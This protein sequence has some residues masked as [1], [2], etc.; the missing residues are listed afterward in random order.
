MYAD[1]VANCADTAIKLQNQI[2]TVSEF[3]TNTGMELNV[4]KT[5]IIVFRNG[6]I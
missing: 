1:D 5:E 2:N 6:G 3:C 4:D